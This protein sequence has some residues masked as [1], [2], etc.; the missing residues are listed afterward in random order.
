VR[1]GILPECLEHKP[2]PGNALSILAHQRGRAVYWLRTRNPAF[3][4]PL[5]LRSYGRS[6]GEPG[7][8]RAAE[9]LRLKRARAMSNLTASGHAQVGRGPVSLNP[10][11]GVDPRAGSCRD[12][13]RRLRW[14][15][16]PLPR[17]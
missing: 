1:L 4:M 9:G 6:A 13:D 7:A 3:A 11:A 8:S 5:C 16:R 14:R 12:G 17:A 15:V 2:D 10:G